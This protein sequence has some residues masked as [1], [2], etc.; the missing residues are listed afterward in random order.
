MAGR[1]IATQ[2]GGVRKVPTPPQR[3]SM[4]PGSRPPNMHM[5]P[6]QRVTPM[7]GQRNYGKPVMPAPN[8]GMGGAMAGPMGQNPFGGT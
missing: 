3:A 8:P 4:V 2:K 6:M 7:Q 1:A 5:P